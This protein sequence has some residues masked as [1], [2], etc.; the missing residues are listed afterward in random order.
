MADIFSLQTFFVWQQTVFP[1]IRNTF[2]AQHFFQI[3]NNN[4]KTNSVSLPALCRHDV[5]AGG[6]L[7]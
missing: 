6:G 5:D 1:L 3:S 7:G 4:E 2:A